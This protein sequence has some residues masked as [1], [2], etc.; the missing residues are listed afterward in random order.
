MVLI[1]ETYSHAICVPQYKRYFYTECPTDE[2]EVYYPSIMFKALIL[3]VLLN[4]SG[5]ARNCH[6]LQRGR[7]LDLGTQC[8]YLVACG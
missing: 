8:P 1:I 3:K 7:F 6:S 2:I 5:L 4:L